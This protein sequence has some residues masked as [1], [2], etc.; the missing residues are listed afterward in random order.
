MLEV[1]TGVAVGTDVVDVFVGAAVGADVVFGFGTAVAVA[2]WVSPSF[3]GVTVGFAVGVGLA[4]AGVCVGVATT[5][6][7]VPVTGLVIAE[8]SCLMGKSVAAA[9]F[10][11]SRVCSAALKRERIFPQNPVSEPLVFNEA[12]VKNTTAQTRI[13]EAAPTAIRFGILH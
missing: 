9:P 6:T 1:A 11:L 12:P 2:P 10:S 5:G 4:V 8:T 13:R 7:G 3:L